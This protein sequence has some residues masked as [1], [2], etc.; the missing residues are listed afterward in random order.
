M[1]SRSKPFLTNV[2]HVAILIMVVPVV[3]Y[4]AILHFSNSKDVDINSV[5]EMGRD[6]AQTGQAI[7]KQFLVPVTL[8]QRKQ[9]SYE[10]DRLEKLQTEVPTH[11]E[12]TRARA[13]ALKMQIAE[14]REHCEIHAS[15]LPEELDSREPLVVIFKRIEHQLRFLMETKAGT[16]SEQFDWK[17]EFIRN[18]EERKATAQAEARDSVPRKMTE[19]TVQLK[20][21]L[22]ESKQENRQLS[23]ELQNLLDGSA[24]SE[25][26]MERS[27]AQRKQREAYL[28]DKGEIESLL[29]PFITPGRLQIGDYL[30]IWLEAD[31][32][33]PLSYSKI[34]HCGGLSEDAKGLK[35]LALIGTSSI[36]THGS[37][38][39]PLGS[40]PPYDEWVLDR[41]NDKARILRAQQLLIKH[42]HYL[43]ELGLL[44]P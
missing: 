10:I 12:Q 13:A 4:G 22:A 8:V 20:Q 23:I 35:S 31:T 26:D 24:Q 29:K 38:A 25:K 16:T 15:D 14:I 28:A 41:P 43:V 18:E 32:A 39:R 7:I 5:D 40:F 21:R 19:E 3:I 1:N 6:A 34:L 17:S 42:G 27:V 11:H 36:S 2:S 9:W 33:A 37:K 30:S 44:A